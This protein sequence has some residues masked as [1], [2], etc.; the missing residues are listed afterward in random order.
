MNTTNPI[1]SELPRVSRL[2]LNGQQS[3][4]ESIQPYLQ[5]PATEQNIKAKFPF[6]SKLDYQSFKNDFSEL[7]FL[8]TQEGLK[9]S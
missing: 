7:H 8:R 3:K 5:M 1:E 2:L 9:S 4:C 6:S